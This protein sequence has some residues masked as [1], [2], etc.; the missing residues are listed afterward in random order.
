MLRLT[1]KTDNSLFSPVYPDRKDEFNISILDFIDGE[2]A[3]YNEPYSSQ[4]K[5]AMNKFNNVLGKMRSL[6]EAAYAHHLR[7]GGVIIISGPFRITSSFY[8]FYFLAYAIKILK[9]LFNPQ[10]FFYCLKFILKIQNSS[11]YKNDDHKNKS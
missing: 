3:T 4:M 10:G 9:A 1:Q 8:L 5:E 11:R 2:I 6:S 7:V